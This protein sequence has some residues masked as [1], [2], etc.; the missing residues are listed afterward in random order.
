MKLVLL[1][2]VG[3][4]GTGWYPIIKARL[5]G[6]LPGRSGAALALAN[7]AGFVGS[8]TPLAL[9]VFAERFGLAAAMW[10]LM[11]CPAALFVALPCGTKDRAA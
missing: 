2:L 10:L 1:G 5:Y 4:C 3:A 8:L 6:V 11:L 7:V 9:G